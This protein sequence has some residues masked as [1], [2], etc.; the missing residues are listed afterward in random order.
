MTMRCT[1]CSEYIFYDEKREKMTMIMSCP[2]CKGKVELM[3]SRKLAGDHPVHPDKTFESDFGTHFYAYVND[4][5]KYFVFK[6][7][8]L[9]TVENPIIA[10]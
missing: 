7:G 10:E 6:N 2:A 9:V 8:K 5:G 4:A 3:R 1:I